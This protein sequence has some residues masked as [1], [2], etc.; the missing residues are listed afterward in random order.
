MT[1]EPDA[2]EQV[3]ASLLHQSQE[4]GVR[5]QAD[6]TGTSFTAVRRE[7]SAVL[8]RRGVDAPVRLVFRAEPPVRPVIIEQSPAGQRRL[9]T[10]L[11][12]LW[13]VVSSA[14]TPPAPTAAELF[15]RDGAG[16]QAPGGRLDGA[17][18][19]G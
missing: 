8:E 9:D 4:G 7:A 19:P 16:P 10:L 14:A 1:G 12:K 18:E 11:T 3:V 2:A 17:D 6:R 5:W 15:L 13:T